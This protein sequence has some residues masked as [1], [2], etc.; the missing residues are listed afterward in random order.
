MKRVYTL[1]FFLLLASICAV[2]QGAKT[3]AT[4]TWTPGVS[5]DGVHP[6]AAVAPM[7]D[8]RLLVTGGFSADGKL[9]SAMEIFD[10]AAN[11]WAAAGSMVSARAGHTVTLMS[12]GHVFLAGGRAA[13]GA[14]FNAE[15]FDPLTAEFSMVELVFPRQDH[16]AAL[17]P[18]GRVLIAGGSDGKQV[19]SSTEIF[20]PETGFVALGPNMVIAR[21]HATATTLADG[22]V[23]IVGGND[24][25]QD[26]TSAEIYD[27]VSGRFSLLPTAMSTARSGH[28]AVL[29]PHNNAVL[30]AGGT[31]DGTVLNSA[32]LYMPWSGTFSATGRMRDARTG[33]AAWPLADEGILAAIGGKNG[34]GAL[35]STEIYHFATL[36]MSKRDYMEGEP[37]SISGTG[38]QPGETV[39]LSV[40]SRQGHGFS[41]TAQVDDGGNIAA[42]FTTNFRVGD[43]FT[44][45]A[46]G[47]QAQAQGQ[48]AT[49]DPS[50]LTLTASANPSPYGQVV[51]FTA[52]VAPANNGPNPSG[53]VTFTVDGAP[54]STLIKLVK[55]THQDVCVKLSLS[56]LTVGSHTIGATYSGDDRYSG[57][58]ASVSQSV[59]KASSSTIVLSNANPSTFG[60]E[61]TLTAIVSPV[62]PAGGTP[63]G[64][65]TFYD[66]AN[67]I[68][69]TT[70]L[71]SGS[72]SLKTSS[73]ITGSHS[74]TVQY[75]G[76]NNFNGSTSAALIETIKKAA[77]T[78]ALTSSANPAAFGSPVTFTA[79]LDAVS[80]AAAATGQIT[81]KDGATTLGT[82]NVDAGGTASFTTSSLSKGS[83][84]ITASYA[85][86]GNY[87][88]S[89]SSTLNQ[90]V[91]TTATTLALTSSQN[92][93]P[94]G[95]S[96]TFT[97]TLTAD[98]GAAAAT[99]Q[100]I[101]KDGSTILATVALAGGGSASY[102]TSTLTVGD[103]SITAQY[104]GDGNF[105]SSTSTTLFQAVAATATTLTLVSSANPS[106]YSQWVTFTATLNAT[107]GA[108]NAT[109]SI[110]FKDGAQ[111][112][113]VVPLNA[114]GWAAFSLNNLGLGAHSITAS[115]NGNSS[116]ASS[117]SNTV[118]QV[119][120]ISPTTTVVVTNI[121][122]SAFGQTITLTV[123]VN[124]TSASQA[125]LSSAPGI[126]DAMPPSGT[127]TFYDG[128]TPLTSGELDGGWTSVNVSTLPVGSH[129]IKAVYAGDPLYLGSTSATITQ[130]V[131]ASS[132]TLN[133]VSSANPSMYSQWTTF[134]ATLSSQNG[135]ASATGNITF[136]DGAQTLA[137]VAVNP[138][139]WAS[140]STNGLTVGN[141][142]I[143][144][145]YN[146]DS[147]FAASNSNAVSQVVN[148]SPTTTLLTTN[149]TPSLFGQTVTFTA[150]VGSTVVSSP[151]QAPS[152]AIALP[153]SGTVTFYDGANAIGTGTL[154]NGWTTLNIASLSAGSHSITAVYLGDGIYNGS[155]SA[156]VTQ[157]VNKATTSTALV[158]STNPAST[159]D[160]VTFT[161]TVTVTSGFAT[162]A[163]TVNFYDGATLI[164]SNALQPGSWTSVNV[165]GLLGGSHSITAQF[166]S[167]SPNV[168]NSTSPALTQ[169]VN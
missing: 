160:I 18:N 148:V 69:T 6:A 136:K 95:G 9:T 167:S 144:A 92:P 46:T 35:L 53:T 145:S 24:G 81:F 157:T 51:T 65:V 5:A 169:T 124:S 26:L 63:T 80:G 25:R 99:G 83:H 52:T 132:T 43:A 154:D 2:A 114:G 68:G 48:G 142:S 8:G 100:I 84:P 105:A 3:S 60:L 147:G 138:G 54:A 131:S 123:T 165:S 28:V 85:G 135:A 74:I 42:T 155:T 112:L 66:G 38:W 10:P 7:H 116:F 4:G 31:A 130:V 79:T 109:G 139:G 45:L 156:A 150:S 161:A 97:A 88:S 44:I 117:N 56:S 11:S 96:V 168:A 49:L 115:Y 55:C 41:K 67:A 118:H 29:L 119:V 13:N 27:P 78:L 72:A 23:L 1:V 50:T 75:G 61:I 111:E 102:T 125:Q 153:A 36:A 19:F 12:D 76:D 107:G 34:D 126:I 39:R 16:V 151:A 82:V 94:F 122:P 59:S 129:S 106:V 101:F 143:T 30:I 162:P 77:T 103:H 15:V 87:L 37:V 40:A 146:G 64:S 71:D 22:R 166:V 110:T 113:A 73:L 149:I 159:V 62:A 158:S 164:G 32:E 98:G 141:H 90:S 93:S 20:D 57:S 120:N 108:G 140:L 58:S 70:A 104:N 91:G 133:L 137:T 134:T 127:V 14:T 128:N 17:L 89:T 47:V 86:D 121:T 152:A 163:G 33:A 21:Q